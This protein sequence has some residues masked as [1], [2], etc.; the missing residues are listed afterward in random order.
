MSNLT[1]RMEDEEKARLTSW[2][3]SKGTTTTAYIKALGA[4]DMAAGTPEQRAAAWF[5][6][7][8]EALK[9]EAD[10]TERH[11]IPGSHLALHY[12]EPDAEV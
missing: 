12:P 11:G 1:I 4:A 5:L 7:N 10:Y 6:E 2:A 8:Q 9:A 3:A